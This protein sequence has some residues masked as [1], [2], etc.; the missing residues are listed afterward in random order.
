MG[1]SENSGSSTVP[2]SNTQQQPKS[3]S[4]SSQPQTPYYSA[5][6]NIPAAAATETKK[7]PKSKK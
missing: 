1:N 6:W 7:D 2:S 3:T 5:T 4:N